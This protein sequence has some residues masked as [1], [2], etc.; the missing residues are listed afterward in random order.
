MITTPPLP[1]AAEYE[2]GDSPSIYLEVRDGAPPRLTDAGHG[3]MR[4]S[5]RVDTDE[6]T[7]HPGWAGVLAGLAEWGVG[8]ERG[9]L[10]AAGEDAERF[11]AALVWF[12]AEVWRMMEDVP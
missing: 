10:V 7:A 2:D 12:E 1:T 9:A 8:Y 11:G 4:L 3:M 5:Y 6:V